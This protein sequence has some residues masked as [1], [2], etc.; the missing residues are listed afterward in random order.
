MP[1]FLDKAKDLAHGHEEQVDSALDKVA[2]LVDG[3]TGGT[4]R[5]QI[6]AAVDKVEDLLAKPSAPKDAKTL[7]LGDPAKGKKKK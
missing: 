4:H 5:H 7:N 6:D 1:D 3:R 2:D